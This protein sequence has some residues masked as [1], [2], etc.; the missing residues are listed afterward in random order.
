MYKAYRDYY[1]E[2]NFYGMNEFSVQYCGDDL[3]FDTEAEAKAFI[4][5]LY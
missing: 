2:F 3:I 4:D 5:S 1:I